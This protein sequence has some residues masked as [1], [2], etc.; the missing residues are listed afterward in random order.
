MRFFSLFMNYYILMKVFSLIKRNVQ[1][2]D[3]AYVLELREHYHQE[4]IFWIVVAGI[5]VFTL[6]SILLQQV[7]LVSAGGLLNLLLISSYLI[8]YL[9]G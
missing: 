7:D 5:Q 3:T 6:N 4:V 9:Y 1:K 2:R 8:K